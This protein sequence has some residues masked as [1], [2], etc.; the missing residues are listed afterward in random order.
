MKRFC[1][2][3]IIL[4]VHFSTRCDAQLFVGP[5]AGISVS[6]VYF[7]D[8]YPQYKTIPTLGFDLGVM[9]SIQVR[10]NFRLNAQLLFSQRGRTIDGTS[11]APPGIRLDPEF[12]LTSKMQFIELPIFYALEFKKVSS[13]EV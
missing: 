13:T 2:C 8:S 10:K 1:Y 12:N 11:S 9:G 6:K 3:L 7:F 5:V 4:S